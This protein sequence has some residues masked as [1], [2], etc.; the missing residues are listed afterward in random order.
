M[1]LEVPRSVAATFVLALVLS[2]PVLAADKGEVVVTFELMLNGHGTSRAEGFEVLF[3]EIPGEAGGNAVILCGPE[4][5]DP[6][7]YECRGN[8][9]VYRGTVA[10][11]AGTAIQFKFLRSSGR[12]ETTG[13]FFKGA[14]TL[15]R[16]I[17]IDA[18]YDYSRPSNEQQDDASSEVTFELTINGDA[19][20]D[21]RFGVSY[22]LQD[23]IRQT[24]GGRFCDTAEEGE[25][26]G[27]TCKGDG[28]IYTSTV[29]V[30]VGSTVY[31]RFQRATFGIPGS[32]AF[33]EGEIEVDGDTTISAIYDYSELEEPDT[34]ESEVPDGLPNSGLGGMA[35]GDSSSGND[36][37]ASVL[38]AARYAFTRRQ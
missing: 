8:G 23:P 14:R 33:K 22:D 16:D 4:A 9:A 20:Q 12:G 13:V 2:V 19:P 5:S 1:L 37:V 28:A 7:N 25:N 3:D 26:T 34:M 30:P 6:D 35:A 21:E 31:Y 10:Y 32:E 29:R 15:E 38:A 24:I 17:I 36:V 18:V 27:V 11:P